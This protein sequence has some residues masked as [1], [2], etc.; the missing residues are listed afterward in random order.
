M[1]NG[2][3]WSVGAELIVC[4]KDTGHQ[5]G[6][7]ILVA[8]ENVDC[9]FGDGQVLG[10]VGSYEAA[11]RMVVDK[12][13]VEQ[14]AYFWHSS[15]SRLIEKPK[16][17]GAK[18]VGYPGYG[19]LF[20]WADERIGGE[21]KEGCPW[22][23]SALGVS[24]QLLPGGWAY[25]PELGLHNGDAETKP[26]ASMSVEESKQYCMSKGYIGFEYGG[27]ATI[28]F[29]NQFTN[30]GRWPGH[31]GMYLKWNGVPPPQTTTSHPQTITLSGTGGPHP[32]FNDSWVVDTAG[33][34]GKV[35]YRRSGNRGDL[36][37]WDGKRW[38]VNGTGPYQGD[39]CAYYHPADTP[40]PPAIGSQHHPSWSPHI[41]VNGGW[42][43]GAESSSSGEAA[44]VPKVETAPAAFLASLSSSIM[45]M[46]SP[47][48]KDA[49]LSSPVA[50]FG[51]GWALYMV[52]GPEQ[53][54]DTLRLGA[55]AGGCGELASNPASGAHKMSEAS[56]D[57]KR[58]TEVLAVGSDGSWAHIERADGQPI[59]ASDAFRVGAA[60]GYRLRFS[61]GVS[62]D[63]PGNDPWGAQANHGPFFVDVDIVQGQE[64]G[65]WMWCDAEF[66]PRRL[67]MGKILGTKGACFADENGGFVW[68]WF[69][70]AVS[71]QEAAPIVAGIIL[72]PP[73]AIAEPISVE[74]VHLAGPSSS[75]APP[76]L[77]EVV[78]LLKKEL[79]ISG[80][81][82]QVVA[83]ACKQLG[84]ET[85]GKSLA[86]QAAE[87]WRLVASA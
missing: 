60:H 34:N 81:I 14:T 16:G 10:G 33:Q 62:K 68:R 78:N 46:I 84:V 47:S 49:P 27:D 11:L 26:T 56:F 40:W 38:T 39:N 71:E 37:K 32:H 3:K 19:W 85:R 24:R 44:G 18:W 63:S 79:G 65:Q 2:A 70:R 72:E 53:H 61:N 58:F 76:P 75:S 77:I 66:D 45:G 54:K 23:E 25:Y 41:V 82:T 64:G 17:R 1:G 15:S 9:C 51:G 22:P 83:E 7:K 30:F 59:P 48:S 73:V 31:D 74:A 80:N 69:G 12:N 8:L 57:S 55:S 86:E 6:G 29:K 43:A 28:Y 67:R 4:G 5:S 20:L 36:I 35:C 52:N 50:Q 42:T 13:D 21:T 87:C